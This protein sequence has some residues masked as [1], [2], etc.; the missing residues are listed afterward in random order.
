MVKQ[1]KI[2]LIA[3]WAIILL[4]CSI[5]FSYHPLIYLGANSLMNFE[6]SLPLIY[7]VLF[8]IFSIFYFVINHKSLMK[9]ISWRTLLITAVL[10]LYATLS[11]LWS[12]SKM[13][14]FLAAGIL[15]TLY[16]TVNSLL[17]IYRDLFSS[18]LFVKKLFK[19]FFGVSVA[20]CV[21][22]FV[23]CILDLVGVDRSCTGMCLGCTYKVFGFPHPNGFMAEPQYLG[24]VLLAP[25]LAALYFLLKKPSRKMLLLTFIFST[26][27]FISFSRGAIYAFAVAL[28]ILV[29]ANIIKQKSARPLFVVPLVLAFFL[30]ALN[31]Q[32]LFAAVSKTNDTYY[33]GVSKVLNQLSLGIIKLPTG[34]TNEPVEVEQENIQ[35][36][37]VEVARQ[38]GYVEASTNVRT[39]LTKAALELSKS[40][41]DVLLFGVGIGNAGNAIYQNFVNPG[42]LNNPVMKELIINNGIDDPSLNVQNEYTE[43]LIEFGIVGVIAVGGTVILWVLMIKKHKDAIYLVTL[44]GAYLVAFLFCSGLT[45]SLYMYLFVPIFYT[46]LKDREYN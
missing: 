6:L 36:K 35:E 20:V 22:C 14:G 25:T 24:G 45:N 32:G 40:R 44:S 21:F 12:D 28:V 31:A 10:P 42:S 26:T 19:V 3:K 27:L 30:V 1:K 8:S 9:N 41:A 16:I 15:W 17:W 23:Q 5:F 39:S 2:D 37:G 34:K 46:A 18:S 13:H 29:T 7:L 11:I 38:S 43:V 33:S 4:P